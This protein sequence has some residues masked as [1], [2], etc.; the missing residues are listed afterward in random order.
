MATGVDISAPARIRDPT[1]RRGTL[2]SDYFV[3]FGA[4]VRADG[5]PSGTLQRRVEG[6]V[7]L[8]QGSRS[9][10]FVATGGVG[11]FGPAE[12]DVMRQLLL[13]RGVGDDRILRERKASD[14]LS[15]IVNCKA[16]LEANR[17]DLGQVYVCSSAYH[18]PRC[19]WLFRLL[20]IKARWGA[21]PADAPHLPLGKLAYFYL[22]EPPAAVWDTLLLLLGRLTG[23]IAR[24]SPPPM[25][26]A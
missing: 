6:A 21:M 14:T 13:E 22:K 10:K 18:N 16:I 25:R 23:R 8:A 7:A 12:A 17:D 9:A 2:P 5:S 4:A 11:R 26:R 24:I 19:A 15:S 3:I 1:E 20:G